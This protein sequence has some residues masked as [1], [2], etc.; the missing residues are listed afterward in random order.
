MFPPIMI[1]IAKIHL[2]RFQRHKKE[3]N[4]TFSA[5]TDGSETVF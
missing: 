3:F 2:F 5:K 1:T 4:L